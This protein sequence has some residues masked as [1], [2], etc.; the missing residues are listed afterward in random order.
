MRGFLGGIMI[1][2]VFLIVVL[3]TVRSGTPILILMRGI[4]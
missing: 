1:L 2:V 4:L 3:F